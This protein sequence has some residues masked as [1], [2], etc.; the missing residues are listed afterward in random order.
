VTKP[1]TPKGRLTPTSR[2][3]AI[4]TMPRTPVKATA[5]KPA[6]M[7]P[8]TPKKATASYSKFYVTN[9]F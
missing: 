3:G 5:A 1:T 4:R 2:Y 8:R 9:R 7:V 6:K